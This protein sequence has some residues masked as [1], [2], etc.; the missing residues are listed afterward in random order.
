MTGTTRRAALAAFS[1]LTDTPADPTTTTTTTT[2]APGTAWA[3]PIAVEGDLTGDG[4]V[5]APG[6]L[7][8][9]TLPIPFRVVQSDVGGHD[10]AE[11]CGR[12]DTLTRLDGGLIWGEGVFDAASPVGTEAARLV[13]EGM[14]TG[15]S[16]DTDDV[17][18]EVRVIADLAPSG[19]LDVED[20]DGG[21]PAPLEVGP[22]GRV[23]VAEMSP[24]DEVMVIRSARIR[25]ATIVAVPAFEQARISLV[26]AASEGGPSDTKSHAYDDVDDDRLTPDALAALTASAIPTEPPEA[27]FADPHLT[28]PTAIHVTRDGRVFG[29]LAVWGTCHIGLPGRC[30]EPP[31][32]PSNYAYFRTGAVYTAEG[33]QVAVGH[34]TLGTGHAGPAASA[35]AAAEHYDNTGAVVVDVAAGEDSH[36]IW[37]AGAVRPG[38]TPDQ[39]R[40]LR[41]APLSGDWRTIGGNLEL[42]GA[43]AVNVPGFPVPRPAGRIDSD[44]MVTLVAA[45]VVAPDVALSAASA[46]VPRVDAPRPPADPTSAAPSKV[47][48]AAPSEAPTLT[49]GD[50]AYLKGLAQ[51]ARRAEARRVSTASR[52][53]DRVDR[54]LAAAKVRRAA[55][56][57]RNV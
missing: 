39:I 43:L 27:W 26:A 49:V 42:V 52:L 15:V 14:R 8:W 48:A 12:I 20:P 3:G 6:A 57:L 41:A 35:R 16:I 44:E 31:R 30:V 47:T 56:M 46:P 45:G 22:D 50:L 51:S 5:I 53:A 34:I 29:H 18:F 19:P 10:G 11:V 4:R 55:R 54:S 28:E 9:D 17:D 40:A 13:A 37:V 1:D 36:G 32:S 7:Y 2:S 25:A 21:D 33:T 38:T 24:D 23:K